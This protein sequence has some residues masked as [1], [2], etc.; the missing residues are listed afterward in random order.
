MGPGTFKE[1][2]HCSSIIRRLLTA[3]L[4]LMGFSGVQ[5]QIRLAA[6]GGIHSSNF[7]QNNSIPGFDTANG[8]Y[9]SPNTGFELGVLAEI[10]LGK[11]NLFFQPGILYAAK[12]NQYQ[13]SY[14]SSVF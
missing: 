4:L 3:F 10:P 12:G 1:A 6:L 2:M 8:K 14:D 9:Y 5:A 11:N 13:R 7:T